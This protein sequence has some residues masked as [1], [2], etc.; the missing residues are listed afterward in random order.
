MVYSIASGGKRIRPIFLINVLSNYNYET[1]A[2]L[3]EA[4][5]SL[6]LMHCASLIHD[7]LPAIDNDDFR[8]GKLTLHKKYGEGE[9]ILTG[10]ALQ[11][12]SFDI[13]SNISNKEI[14]IEL[15]KVLSSK[16]GIRGMIGGQILDISKIENFEQMYN[17]MIL[18]TA[19]LFEASLM[20]GGIIGKL[21]DNQIKSLENFGRD[22]GLLFQILDDEKDLESDQGANIFKYATRNDIEN[23]KIKL[24]ESII[25]CMNKNFDDRFFDRFKWLFVN[26][27]GFSG[28]IFG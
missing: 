21:S 10:D 20:M 5:L 12:M 2:G 13:L 9:A 3:S 4:V 14:A 16:S 8:R 24:I 28:D 22:V 1:I 23:L 11:I 27:L 26:K 7:D 19:A 17:I 25:L 18:K 15:V 6:E